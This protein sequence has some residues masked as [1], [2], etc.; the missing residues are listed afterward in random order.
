MTVELAY[1]A[2]S[3]VLVFVQVM[4]AAAAATRVRGRDWNAGPRDAPA[5]PLGPVGGRLERAARNVLETF[6]LFAAAVL[7]A[8]AADAQSWLSVAGASLYF[9]GRLVYLPL[10][11]LG[12]PYIRSLVWMVATAGIFLILA[13]LI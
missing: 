1:L 13:A 5:A 7:T 8:H 4:L 12:I 11:V 10:Y 3:I 2:A 6:P 9:W